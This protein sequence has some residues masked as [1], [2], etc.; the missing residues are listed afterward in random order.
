MIHETLFFSHFRA[1][2]PASDQN[3][4]RIGEMQEML[5]RAMMGAQL[6]QMNP[7][8][9]QMAQLQGLNPL[10]TMNLYP[11][12]IPPNLLK[13]GG[14]NP[15]AGNDPLAQLQANHPLLGASGLDPK[16][17]ALM[18]AARQG[19]SNEGGAAAA[20]PQQPK[21]LAQILCENNY[22]VSHFTEMRPIE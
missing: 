11:P 15:G 4:S 8:M 19:G 18:S 13:Q 20:A 17:L 5:Q 3:E 16:L 6:Q 10:I 21:N 22:V 1:N 2:T 7:L 14:V 12:L 9:M